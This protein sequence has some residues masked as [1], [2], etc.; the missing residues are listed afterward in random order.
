MSENTIQRSDT[1]SDLQKKSKKSKLHEFDSSDDEVIIETGQFDTE[2]N[3]YLTTNFNIEN[4]TNPL[5]FW[6]SQQITF[7]ILSQLAVLIL[8]AP[9][10]SVPSEC[11]FSATGYLCWDRRNRLLPKNLDMITFIYENLEVLK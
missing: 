6:S 3:N 8:A 11:L 1:I 5:L 4:D 2:F 10:T 7:P 9:A